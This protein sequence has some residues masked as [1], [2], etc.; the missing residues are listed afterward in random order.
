MTD[1]DKDERA[2]W[3]TFMAASLDVALRIPRHDEIRSV[4]DLVSDART[5][6]DAML[7][8]RRDRWPEKEY[9]NDKS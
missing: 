3:D 7:E 5:L 4:S 1:H 8:E 6:A 2:A 9:A